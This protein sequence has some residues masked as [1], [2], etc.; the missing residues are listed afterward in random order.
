MISILLHLYYPDSLDTIISE[1]E[2]FL[3]E[4]TKL[5]INLVSS[6]PFDR[7]K[8]PYKKNV[9]VYRSSNKGKDIGGKLVLID[10]LMALNDTNKYLI[11]L[12]DKKS[13]H[14]PTG[15]FWKESLFAIIKAENRENILKLLEKE[16]NA[17]IAPRIFIKNEWNKK[18]NK[19]DTTNNQIL[20]ELV[21]KYNIN[22]ANKEFVAGT[23][24]WCKSEPVK[25]FFSKYNALDI[26]S[27]LENGSV[28]DD[29][30]G[31]Y[32]HSWERLLSWLIISDNKRIAAYD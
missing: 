3:T 24:F 12:H 27:T 17:I 6:S 32:T 25:K 31:T 21:K 1:I 19:F 18:E 30:S 23:M 29:D 7:K 26:R 5:Y 9:F 22:N 11:F 20:C 10:A 4:E 13:P 15:F 28:F 2:F 14:S 8:V 16:E